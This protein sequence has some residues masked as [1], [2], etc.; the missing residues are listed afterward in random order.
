MIDCNEWKTEKRHECANMGRL[1][2]LEL[3]W[4]LYRTSLPVRNL[5]NFRPMDFCWTVCTKTSRLILLREIV[6]I[7]CENLYWTIEHIHNAEFPGIKACG[8]YS[9]HRSFI[10]VSD[11]CYWHVT[12]NQDA[13]TSHTDVPFT[14]FSATCRR[15]L[16]AEEMCNGHTLAPIHTH[17]HLDGGCTVKPA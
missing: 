2:R 8:T 3:W 10:T 17:T 11:R 14:G 5:E 1:K 4:Q 12:L 7:Y 6:G 13:S 16:P 9:D 15:M